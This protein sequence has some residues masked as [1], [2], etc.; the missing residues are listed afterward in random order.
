[1]DERYKRIKELSD[2]HIRLCQHFIDALNENRPS[3]ELNAL[4]V[5]I[6]LILETIDEL[7]KQQNP[8]AA[9]D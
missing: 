9:I 6:K 8:D 3:E 7:E 4:K 5:Q 2:D 1:M